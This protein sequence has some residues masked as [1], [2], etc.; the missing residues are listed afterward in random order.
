MYAWGDEELPEEEVDKVLHAAAEKIHTFGMDMIAILAL[1]TVKPISN[2]GGELSRMIFSPFLPALGPEYNMMGDKLIYVFQRRENVEK[3]IKLLEANIKK[4]EE[5][6]AE[7][8]KPPEEQVED[9]F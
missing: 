9:G 7:K 8:K 1:E 5:K 6:A 4:E 3:L 2:M